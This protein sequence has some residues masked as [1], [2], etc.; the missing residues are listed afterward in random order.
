MIMEIKIN[1]LDHEEYSKLID[2]IE[3]A[4]DISIEGEKIKKRSIY[5]IHLENATGNPPI[6]RKIT[7][8]VQD[9]VLNQ[10]PQDKQTIRNS[11]KGL[12]DLLPIK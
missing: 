9:K 12:I 7:I 6:Y 4:G 8:T 2:Y 11:L 1:S 10:F 5:Q 3:K